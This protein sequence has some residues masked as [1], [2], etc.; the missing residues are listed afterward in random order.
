[1]PFCF[2]IGLTISVLRRRLRY[3]GE[4][5]HSHQWR[6]SRLAAKG[7]RN[8][9]P[10]AHNANAAFH[11]FAFHEEPADAYGHE[12][13][14]KKQTKKTKKQKPMHSHPRKPKTRHE[15][16]HGCRRVTPR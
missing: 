9:S 4:Y 14:K 3:G 5:R 7:C 11:L 2:F 16:Q 6:S 8:P 10:A 15:T 13:S 12:S 1:M